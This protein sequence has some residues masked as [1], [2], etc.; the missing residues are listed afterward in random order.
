[1]S[2]LELKESEI[3]KI[4]IVMDQYGGS[5]VKQ[6]ARLYMAADPKNKQKLLLSFLSYFNEY[7]KKAQAIEEKA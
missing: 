6:L 7:W 4:L 1:M 3:E 5:F 2:V